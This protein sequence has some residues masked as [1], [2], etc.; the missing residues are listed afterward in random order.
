MRVS[1]LCVFEN[2]SLC[3]SMHYKIKRCIRK[4]GKIILNVPGY[5]SP[6]RLRDI[7]DDLAGALVCVGGWGRTSDSKYNCIITLYFDMKNCTFLNHCCK[8][9]E[10]HGLQNILWS[11]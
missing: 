11:L 9:E 5:V 6:I 10:T 8:V 4:S 7:A 1:V 2:I 3:V